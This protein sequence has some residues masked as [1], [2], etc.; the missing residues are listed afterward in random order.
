MPY[1]NPCTLTTD[2][3]NGFHQS[4]IGISPIANW[5]TVPGGGQVLV[6]NDIPMRR[7]GNE[8]V[9]VGNL[10]ARMP[11]DLVADEPAMIVKSGDA[12]LS[13]IP[14]GFKSVAGK[15][16]LDGVG[17]VIGRQWNKPMKGI[18]FYRLV[19]GGHKYEPF[20]GLGKGHP[21]KIRMQQSAPLGI[22]TTK[23][24]GEVSHFADAKGKTQLVARPSYL[25]NPADPEAASVPVKCLVV[26]E[27][28]ITYI[29][30]ILPDGDWAGWVVDPTFTSPQDGL[31]K[32]NRLDSANYLNFGISPTIYAGAITAHIDRI[33]I[34]FDVSSLVPAV[35][36]SGLMYLYDED[37][38]LKTQNNFTVSAYRILPGNAWPEGTQNGAQAAGESCWAYRQYNTVNWLGSAGCSTAGTDYVALAESSATIPDPGAGWR[39][40]SIT[41][42]AIAWLAGTENNGLLVKADDEATIG[43][44]I[45]ASAAESTTAAQR[46]YAVFTYGAAAPTPTSTTGRQRTGMLMGMQ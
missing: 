2:L 1:T 7:V 43:K 8:L 16:Y 5:Q 19:Y 12:G 10:E 13:L 17:N 40:W 27:H 45:G 18:D 41:A 36:T 4:V 42:A 9:A 21:Q 30:L 29:D 35:A 24:G 38:A 25:Y 15:D 11:L 32:D 3:G 37:T 46:P 23:A 34:Q 20:F 31:G 14:V 26:V 44:I 28:G 22:M 33:L 6:A 39:Q